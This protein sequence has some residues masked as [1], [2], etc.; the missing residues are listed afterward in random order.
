MFDQ[1][2]A[3]QMEFEALVTRARDV[4]AALREFDLERLDLTG[5]GD[6]VVAVGSVVD[7]ASSL[8]TALRVVDAMRG[9]ANLPRCEPQRSVRRA[10]CGPPQGT[11]A[12]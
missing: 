6:A 7:Q 11:T 3:A 5:R 9:P 12:R 4:V 10:E 8:R 2:G 1:D